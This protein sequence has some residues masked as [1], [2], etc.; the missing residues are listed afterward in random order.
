MGNVV[1]LRA[2]GQSQGSSDLRE[3]E[4]K[5]VTISTFETKHQL[6]VYHRQ[7]KNDRVAA[8]SD[9]R[10]HS[11]TVL[12]PLPTRPFNPDSVSEGQRW[13]ERGNAIGWSDEFPLQ[14][15]NHAVQPTASEGRDPPNHGRDSV[16]RSNALEHPTGREALATSYESRQ[17]LR[18]RSLSGFH[19]NVTR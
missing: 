18:T 14:P 6:I 15:T 19:R 16:I 13:D 12:S 5:V 9:H 1:H 3:T 8:E 7:M 4:G 17:H 10:P 2:D 11:T